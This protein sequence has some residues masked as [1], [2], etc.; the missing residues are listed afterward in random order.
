MTPKPPCRPKNVVEVTDEVTVLD[1][2]I[3]RIDQSLPAIH[4]MC[5]IRKKQSRRKAT[6][7]RLLPEQAKHVKAAFR[8]MVDDPLLTE[9]GDDI[10]EGPVQTINGFSCPEA[11]SLPPQ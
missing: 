8:E 3:E 7:D 10:T 6:T 2:V 9:S 5:A 4:R 1:E 11:I